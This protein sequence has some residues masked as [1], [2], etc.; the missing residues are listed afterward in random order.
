MTQKREKRKLVKKDG[1]FYPHKN[2]K[3]EAWVKTEKIYKEAYRNP[4]KFWGNLAKELAWFKKWKKT[5]VHK[6]PY[7]KWFVGGKL[8]ITYNIFERNFELGRKNKVAIIWEPEPINERP[9]MLTYYQLYREVNKL[10][11]ALKKLGVKKGDVV[12]IYLPMIPEVQI[13]CARIGAVHAVVFSAFSAHALKIRL[14]ETEAKILITADGYYRRGKVLNLK[15][16]ADKG[17]EGTKVKKVI[18]VKRAGNQINWVE[19]R[20]Y[21]YHELVEGESDYC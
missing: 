14:E 16:K 19:K 12:G 8:N 20:D 15:E 2:L 18:V 10:A 17:V 9:R 7:F 1:L 13:A 5:F 6:P 3:K 11:N 21:W 4:V